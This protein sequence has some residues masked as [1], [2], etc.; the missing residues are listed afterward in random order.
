M[1]KFRLKFTLSDG[2]KIYLTEKG[3]FQLVEAHELESARVRD[4]IEGGAYTQTLGMLFA[5]SSGAQPD[6]VRIVSAELE[7]ASARVDKSA[8]VLGGK[9]A[10][11]LPLKP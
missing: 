3:Q 11:E 5:T 6:S 1:K 10:V 9:L 7:P 2:R 4:L 8:F